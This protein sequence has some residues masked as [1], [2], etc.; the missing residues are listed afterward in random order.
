MTTFV[1]TLKS[2]GE[3]VY[4]YENDVAVEFIGY[5]FANFDH[6]ELASLPEAEPPA[7]VERR[8]MFRLAF[9]RR[10]TDQRYMALQALARTEPI[11]ALWLDKFKM[12]DPIGPEGEHV[13]RADPRT[14]AGLEAIKGFP[15]LSLNQNDIEQILG[16][17]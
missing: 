2:T 6:T 17:F 10:F 14:R 4:R 3:E 11:A 9:I 8:W 7:P 15:T 16:G 13:D 5:E 12:L 1:V